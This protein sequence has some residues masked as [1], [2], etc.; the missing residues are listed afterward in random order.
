MAVIFN[1]LNILFDTTIYVSIQRNNSIPYFYT[2]NIICSKMPYSSY[3]ES[4]RQFTW[5][6]H[7]YSIKRRFKTNFIILLFFVLF[8]Y[9]DLLSYVHITCL[10]I[11]NYRNKD[12]SQLFFYQNCFYIVEQYVKNSQYILFIPGFKQK[13][14]NIWLLF[15]CV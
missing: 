2:I 13:I 1:L 15:S 7:K 8:S 9:Y 4:R 6:S 12:N 11:L 5:A 14:W 10:Y 3:C